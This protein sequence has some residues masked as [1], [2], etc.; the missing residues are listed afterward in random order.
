MPTIVQLDKQTIDQIAAGEVIERPA[1][2]VKELTENAVDAGA[3]AVTVEIKGG[4]T[5]L[6]RV[7]DNGCGIDA[8][9]VKLA[10]AR[11]ATSKIRTAADLIGVTSLGFRGEALSSIAS[12]AEVELITKTAEAVEGS[13]YRIEN[14]EEK[15]LSAVGAPNGTTFLVKNLFGAVPARRKFLKTAAT[16]SAYVTEVCEKLALSNPAVSVRLIVNGQT[17]LDTSGNGKLKDVIYAVYGRE[18]HE[19][20]LPVQGRSQE[21]GAELSG[22]VGKPVIARGNR[23]Y[24]TVFV[25]G[26]SITSGMISRAVEEAFKPFMMQHRYPFAVLDIRIP[27]EYLDVNVHPAKREIRFRSEDAIYRMVYGAVKNAL[28]GREFIADVALTEE[29]RQEAP[30]GRTGEEPFEKENRPQAPI[31]PAAPETPQEAVRE[32]AGFGR[33]APSVGG[34]YRSLGTYHAAPST[35]SSGSFRAPYAHA[36]NFS[37]E[38]TPYRIGPKPEPSVAPV[39]PA[40]DPAAYQNVPEPQAVLQ[41]Q[42]EQSPEEKPAPKP[43]QMTLFDGHFLDKQAAVD[44]RIIGQVFGTFWLIEMGDKFYI[45]DQHAAHEKIL[46]ERTVKRLAEEQAPD[47]QMVSPPVIVQVSEREG[48]VL[49]THREVFEKLGYEVTY[50][51]GREYAIGAV[52]AGALGVDPRALFLE[53]LDGLAAEGR[54]SQETILNKAASLSCKAAIKGNHTYSLA[55]AQSLIDQLMQ[56]EN[57]YACPHG[58]PT[59]ISFTRTELDKKFKRI[60]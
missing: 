26:R 31:R 38:A 29:V 41:P 16:E 15:G 56:C 43:E 52:P 30:A 40:E 54:L 20:L 60:V 7:T 9:Q 49:R 58:R 33:P 10:F 46:Y 32:M 44:R 6:I 45:M 8:D 23:G 59:L 21:L 24:E 47:S 12:V 4:G 51:G 53:V 50:Y 13:D 37:E 18:I 25:N 36:M 42:P 55:E 34:Q 3:T 17:K 2:V 22:F 14:G 19:N 1:S 57:P 39:Q 28:T 48:E 27:G 35:P 5:E 11:H